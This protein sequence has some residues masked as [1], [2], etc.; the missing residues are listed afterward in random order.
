LPKIKTEVLVLHSLRH[1]M[2]TWQG[3]VVPTLF[4]HPVHHFENAGP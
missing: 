1:T 4:A 3:E 2:L